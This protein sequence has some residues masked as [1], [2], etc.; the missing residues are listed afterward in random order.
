MKEELGGD[1]SESLKLEVALE[2]ATEAAAIAVA[3][4]IPRI[5]TEPEMKISESVEVDVN[6]EVPPVDCL[7]KSTQ[8][9]P[10]YEPTPITYGICCRTCAHC[11]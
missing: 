6:E 8:K 4:A 7:L 9:K 1:V 3:S 2:S 11:G 5:E 10:P